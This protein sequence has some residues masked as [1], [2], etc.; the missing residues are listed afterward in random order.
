MGR[1]PLDWDP[2]RPFQGQNGQPVTGLNCANLFHFGCSPEA[3]SAD[4]I[5]SAFSLNGSAVAV[6]GSAISQPDVA[7]CLTIAGSGSAMSSGSAVI[8][9]KNILG[10]T[11]TESIAASGSATATGTKA[12]SS[13]TSILTPG[14]GS[15]LNF[16]VGVSKKIGVPFSFSS[17]AVLVKQLFDGAVDAG[18]LTVDAD[19]V[20]KNVYEPAGTPDGSKM[21]DLFGL[22]W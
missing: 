2:D 17:S 18:T 19:E 5:V 10:E 14:S 11:I 15:G 8:S 22:V 1:Y 16:N 7:R 4:G 6:P 9:G 21:V 13:I 20:E 3:V 12:F